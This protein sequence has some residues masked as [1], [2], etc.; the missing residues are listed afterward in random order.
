MTNPYLND[1]DRRRSRVGCLVLVTLM[2][3][4][5][6]VTVI[7]YMRRNREDRSAVEPQLRIAPVEEV[8]SKPPARQPR[9]TPKTTAPADDPG[10]A[11]LAEL[12]T[13]Q[14]NEALQ[15]ARELGWRILDESADDAAR[16][17]A[18]RILGEIHI[19]LVMSPRPMPEK[20]DYT[21]QSGDSLAV[22]ARRFG[23]TVELIQRGNRLTGSR[24]RAGDRLR[25]LQA[26]FS[27]E[28]SK[29]DNDL[30]L[31]MNDRFFKRYPV[32]TGEYHR[33]PE[34]E[35]N[36]TERIAQPTWWRQDGK[37]IPF[38][39]TNNVLGTHWLSINVPGYGLHG[40]WE[41]E[42]IGYQSSAGCV[43]MHNHDIEEL[44]TL[45]P[46]GVPVRIRE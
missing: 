25:I 17:E 14:Q 4:A 5:L 18:E 24:I 39:T 20:V 33:T 31:F 46:V 29:N 45:L 40:T 32:G 27:L 41:P 2:V 6:L 23:T 11:L 43:R 16:R 15:P 37:A 13:L 30:V 19:T 9:V 7:S 1:L 36:I 10:P 21:I 28:I 8:E 34:G 3:V 26:E 38:G 35:F 22:L 42:T 12:K 44:F